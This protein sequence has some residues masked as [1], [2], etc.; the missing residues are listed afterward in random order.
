MVNSN[1][2]LNPARAPRNG[3]ERV[4]NCDPATLYEAAG[5]QSMGD[6]AIRPA[7][8]GA[9]VCGRAV[10]MECTPSD[11]LML[12]IAVADAGQPGLGGKC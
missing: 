9:K 12:H 10:T 3:V 11:N 2:N 7:W 1:V 8:V 4:V 6:P 5:Q